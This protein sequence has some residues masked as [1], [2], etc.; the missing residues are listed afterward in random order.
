MLVSY[1]ALWVEKERETGLSLSFDELCIV[2][3]GRLEDALKHGFS[4]VYDTLNNSKGWRDRLQNI[5]VCQ[6]AHS[7]IIYLNTPRD[8]IEQRRT[9][10][11]L[12]NQRHHVTSETLRE[13]ITKF[14]VPEPCERAIEF[15]PGTD[16]SSWLE[17]LKGYGI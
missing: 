4:A 2:A 1:D 15:T 10:N 17:Q 12:T 7:V 8:I 13:E 3:E 5:A 6:G 11:E 14:E 16:V 9:S